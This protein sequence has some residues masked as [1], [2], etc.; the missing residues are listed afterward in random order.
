MLS[1]TGPAGF[2][3]TPVNKFLLGLSLS[4]SLALM[5]PLHQYR[6]LCTYSYDLVIERGEYWRML[7]SK[8]AFLDIKDIV[9]C[10]MLIYNFRFLE[11]RFGSRKYASYLLGVS[12]FTMLLEVGALLLCQCLDLKLSPLPSGPFCLV[13]PQFVQFFLMIPRVAAS[14]IMGVPVTGKTFTYILGLQVA[15]GTAECRLVA[16]CAVTAGLLWQ[17]NFLKVQ[18]II[19]VPEFVSRTT[20]RLAGWLFRSA[21]PTNLDSPIGATLELQRQER[22]ERMEEQMLAA[23][24]RNSA[25]GANGA[26][27]G[28]MRP[29]PLN[30]ANGP[31]I[32]GN[33]LRSAGIHRGSSADTQH[34]PVS[35]EQVQRLIEMGFS[36]DSVRRALRVADN[37]ISRATAVLLQEAS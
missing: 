32:F 28:M 15:S 37:D 23:A 12:V 20:D 5:F 14:T 16:L 1:V 17:H 36:D 7:T 21:R 9:L 10:C 11:R 18:S 6:H 34:S 30:L 26:G 3:Q 29:Q 24:M 33:F 27:V 8:V 19:F 31:G 25:L 35:E 22:L 2:Y 4:S 13:F